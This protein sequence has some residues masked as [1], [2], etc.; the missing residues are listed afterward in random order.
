MTVVTNA[1]TKFRNFKREAKVTIYRMTN[2]VSDTEFRP[3]NAADDLNGVEITDMRIQFDI[4]RTLKKHPNNCSVKLTNL[5][6]DTRKLLTKKPLHM[7][8]EAGYDGVS[9]I[10][11]SGDVIFAM[12]EQDGADF[13]T[14]IQCGDGDRIYSSARAKSSYGAGTTVK[15]VLQDLA[16]SVGQ[17][18]PRNVLD[19][20]DLDQ[21]L[22]AGSVAFGD[23]RDEFTRL[24]APYG[25]SW[26][27]QNGKLQILRDSETDGEFLISEETGMIGTPEFGTPRRNGKPPHVTVKCLLFPELRPGGRVQVKS[28][29]LDG[30]FK[31]EKVKHNGDTHGSEWVTEIEIKLL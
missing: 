18:L 20:K 9:R 4:D 11:Y 26:S 13:T 27:F 31:I 24:L 25:Y 28:K 23:L 1:A 12:T 8:L 16:G 2:P 7:I 10:M 21:Q 15:K 3:T 30:S 6:A 22:T 14:L 19:S 5:N 17:T 29:Y